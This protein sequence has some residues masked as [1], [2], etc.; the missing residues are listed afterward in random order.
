MSTNKTF[1]PGEKVGVHVY[2]TNVEALEFRVYRVKDP[3]TFFERLDNVHNF[4]RV[5][6]KEQVENPS[7]LESF[8]DWK[9]DLWVEIRDFFR[10]Q[11]SPRSRA[12]IRESQAER[13]NRNPARLTS[14]RK[15][16]C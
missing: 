10:M 8:H 7:F 12:Q 3:I 15:Y 14:L 1:L 11:F 16:L 6:P 13:A 9:H 2:S 5:S 4:G